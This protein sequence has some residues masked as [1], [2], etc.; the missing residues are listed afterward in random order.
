MGQKR[1]LASSKPGRAFG[2]ASGRGKA[3][4]RVGLYARVSMHDQQ[5][6]RL[7]IRTMRDY[8]ARGSWIIPVQVKEVGPGAS[9]REFQEKLLDAVSD[10]VGQR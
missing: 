7:H 5:T 10:T 1:A 4:L 6:I 3:E 8:A 2:R 9:Q